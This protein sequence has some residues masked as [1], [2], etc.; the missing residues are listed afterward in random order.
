MKERQPTSLAEISVFSA[1]S[2]SDRDRLSLLARPRSFA[3]NKTIFLQGEPGS[4]LY[5]IQS[6]RVKICAVAPD[7]MEL[8]FAFLSRGD[9]LGELAILDGQPRSATAIAVDNTDTLFIDRKEFMDFLQVSP[10]ACIDIM[11]MLCRRLRK[12]DKHL[13]EISFLDVSSRLARKLGEISAPDSLPD[14][15]QE[16][17]LSCSLSQEELASMV[18]A[19]RVMVNKILNSFVDMGLITLSRKKITLIDCSKL[20]RIADYGL[21]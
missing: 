16:P 5:I 4:G 10:V 15:H 18:G 9:L 11:A 12:T 19:S 20:A 6:G 2:P 21:H 3:A 13:E 17:I 14:L 7:G 1:L 8:I